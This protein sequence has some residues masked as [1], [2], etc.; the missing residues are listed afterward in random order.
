MYIKRFD[1]YISIELLEKILCKNPNLQRIVKI[2]NE[3]KDAVKWGKML[4]SY[5]KNQGWTE[6]ECHEG[7]KTTNYK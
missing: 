7:C 1:N 4:K 6:G 3:D 2:V 5:D